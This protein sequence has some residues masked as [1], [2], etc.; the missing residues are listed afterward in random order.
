MKR[1]TLEARAIGWRDGYK[2]GLEVVHAEMATREDEIF[3]IGYRTGKRTHNRY[4]WGKLFGVVVIGSVI[5][6]GIIL[7]VA[8]GLSHV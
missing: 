3:K 7:A 2:H 5:G 6:C 8:V 4:Q 1:E